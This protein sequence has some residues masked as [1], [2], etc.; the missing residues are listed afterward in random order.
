MSLSKK[1]ISLLKDENSQTALIDG[2]DAVA[3]YLADDELLSSIPVVNTMVSVG[4]VAL[5]YRDRKLVKKN[6]HFS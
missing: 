5:S 1:F 3:G 4:K 6:K 2:A